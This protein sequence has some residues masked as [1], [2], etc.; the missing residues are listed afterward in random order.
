LVEDEVLRTRLGRQAAEYAR[1]YAW[2]LIVDQVL[3]LYGTLLKK[4]A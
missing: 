3:S 1:S 4:H 2:P